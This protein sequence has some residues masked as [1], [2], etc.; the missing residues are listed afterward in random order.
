MQADVKSAD[1]FAI[2]AHLGA[3]KRLRETARPRGLPLR[4]RDERALIRPYVNQQLNWEQNR[5][6]L[7]QAG[8]PR[9]PN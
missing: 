4:P 1:M 3:M 6:E 8:L 2:Y 9:C 7:K 5:E